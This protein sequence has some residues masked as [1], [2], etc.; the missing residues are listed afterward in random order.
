MTDCLIITFNS[1]SIV[2]GANNFLKIETQQQVTVA[3]W[4][5]NKLEVSQR[6]P[7]FTN[8]YIDRKAKNR[9]DIPDDIWKTIKNSL[10]YGGFKSEIIKILNN[11][12][13]NEEMQQMITEYKDRPY[14]PIL[15]LKLRE[16]I[17]SVLESSN[18]NLMEQVNKILIANNYKVL[19]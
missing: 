2:L 19:E 10:D 9:S 1:Y 16:E 6:L 11:N 14:I 12:F 4:V 18:R 3:E 5:Y 13:T 7:Y 17:L 15:R 8:K